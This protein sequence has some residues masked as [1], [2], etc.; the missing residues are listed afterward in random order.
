MKVIGLTG[1]M[2][3]GKSTVAGMLGELGAAVI[4][5]DAVARSIRQNDGEARAEIEARFGTLEPR[6]LAGMVFADAGALRNPTA[7]TTR[8]GLA[9]FLPSGHGLPPLERVYDRCSLA[10]SGFPAGRSARIGPMERSRLCGARQGSTGRP[11]RFTE[12]ELV[13]V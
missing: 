4:D 10:R 13:L 9:G 12:G 6:Q 1:N 3:C 8:S 11:S 7:A 5:A 2:G